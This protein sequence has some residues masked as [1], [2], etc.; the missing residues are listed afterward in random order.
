MFIFRG[1]IKIPKKLPAVENIKIIAFFS[2]QKK[3]KQRQRNPKTQQ[4]KR[5]DKIPDPCARISLMHGER[6][7][8]L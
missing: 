6:G 4:K 7:V 5:P 1:T 8:V 3:K 2:Y